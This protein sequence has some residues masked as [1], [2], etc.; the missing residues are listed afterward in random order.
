MQIQGE[1][2]RKFK[3]RTIQPQ[4]HS[5]S[6]AHV[7]SE[8]CGAGL[9]G[10]CCLVGGAQG[11]SRELGRPRMGWSGVRSGSRQPRKMVDALALQLGGFS[12]SS[13][14]LLLSRWPL[15][16]TAESMDKSLSLSLPI[17]KMGLF[18][19]MLPGCGGG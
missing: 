16:V 15:R 10:H 19:S 14:C 6:L 9:T 3:P 5:A 11:A 2:A 17:C 7:A 13:Q 12:S 8:C 18:A 4:T 1:E